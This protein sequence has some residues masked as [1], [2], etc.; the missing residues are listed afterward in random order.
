MSSAT[1][2]VSKS[3][4]HCGVPYDAPQDFRVCP[5]HPDAVSA[6]GDTRPCGR[7]GVN[8]QDHEAR[9][10]GGVM[11]IH[12]PPATPTPSKTEGSP[13]S[14][15]ADTACRPAG[16]KTGATCWAR[17]GW[18]ADC[19]ALGA[20]RSSSVAEEDDLFDPKPENKP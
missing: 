8:M 2:N 6:L 18:C 10:T 15:G 13:C 17:C 20:A 14:P 11:A 4:C 7:C 1:P 3:P 5:N 12:C 9:L 16:P 19:E